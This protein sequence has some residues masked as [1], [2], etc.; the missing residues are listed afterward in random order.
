MKLVIGNITASRIINGIDRKKLTILSVRLYTYGSSAMPP[1]W[2]ITSTM[3]IA[4]PIIPAIREDQ[5]VI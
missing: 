2:V 5:N 4:K 3:P 1:F